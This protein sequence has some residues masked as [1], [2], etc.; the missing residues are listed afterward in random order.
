MKILKFLLIAVCA[1]GLTFAQAGAAKK[2]SSKSSAAATKADTKAKAT[3]APSG[4]LVDINSASEDDLKKLDG[5]GDAYA[6]KI[7]DNRPY[8]AK[9][10]LTRKKVVP[11]A[12]YA[13]IKDK[14]IAKQ[15]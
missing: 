10:D 8:K 5:I 6:K 3:S 7:V 1:A 12:T 15:K 11:P 14:I 4:D 9:T 2:A 13:K